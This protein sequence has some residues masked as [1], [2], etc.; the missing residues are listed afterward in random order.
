MTNS[1]Q[2]NR[3][4]DKDHVAAFKAHLVE[5]G[6]IIPEVWPVE[7][8][9]TKSVV[10]VKAI[11]DGKPYYFEL[12]AI[13]PSSGWDKGR[14]C[15]GAIK[16]NQVAV[17]QVL[18]NHGVDFEYKVVWSLSPEI[19]GDDFLFHQYDILEF[20]RIIRCRG[21][22]G[23]QF[24]FTNAFTEDLQPICANNRFIPMEVYF[25]EYTRLLESESLLTL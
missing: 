10:D 25:Q 6:F 20:M 2:A 23:D 12:K 21:L 19:T 11:K 17:E 15:F 16:L 24:K 7:F 9:D 22:K 4:G 3:A 1:Q 8:Y 13:N 5:Q 18:V 14:K